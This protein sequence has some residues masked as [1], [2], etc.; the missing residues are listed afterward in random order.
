MRRS[1]LSGG[2]SHHRVS[3]GIPIDPEMPIKIADRPSLADMLDAVWD[4]TMTRHCA[5]PG[6]RSGMAID[7][8]YHGAMVRQRVEQSFDMAQGT[9]IATCTFALRRRSARIEPIRRGDRK[10]TDIAAVFP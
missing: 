2:K 9:G 7:H 5:E 4:H 1:S 8:G 3:D 6:E 10:H